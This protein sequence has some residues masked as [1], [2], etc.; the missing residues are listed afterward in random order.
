[1]PT[2]GVAETITN[3]DTWNEGALQVA[4]APPP[5]EANRIMPVYF[6]SKIESEKAV[7]KFVKDEKLPWVVNSVS[8]CCIL[9]DLRNDKHLRSAPP[10][11][12]EGL[13]LGSTDAVK[14]IAAGTS[15]PCACAK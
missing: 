2:P 13:Y 5:Y 11:F 9:G 7:W 3:L 10:Q 8:P 12:L 4:W 15:R 1:M 6:A 14:G